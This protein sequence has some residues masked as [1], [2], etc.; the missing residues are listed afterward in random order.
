MHFFLQLKLFPWSLTE[1]VDGRFLFQR[2]FEPLRLSHETSVMSA[3]PPQIVFTCFWQLPEIDT[4]TPTQKT[5]GEKEADRQ[6]EN[7]WLVTSQTN[8]WRSKKRVCLPAAAL[9]TFPSAPNGRN[10]PPLWCTNPEKSH[11]NSVISTVS[12]PPVMKQKEYSQSQTQ[13]KGI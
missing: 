6:R 11:H 3:S 1:G 7:T 13:I 4:E 5:N 8:N 12:S 2:L 10:V 9:Q